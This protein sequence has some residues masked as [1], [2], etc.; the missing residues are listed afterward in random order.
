MRIENCILQ[1]MKSCGTPQ[2]TYYVN[3]ELYMMQRVPVKSGG[4]KK[5]HKQAFMLSSVLLS[6]REN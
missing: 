3:E 4:W 5:K 6:S 1:E 2:R